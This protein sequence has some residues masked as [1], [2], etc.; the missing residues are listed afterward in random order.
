MSS[1][2]PPTPPIFDLNLLYGFARSCLPL[3]LM[4]CSVANSHISQRS[5]IARFMGPTW[6]TWTLL[7]GMCC[8][9]NPL[10]WLQMNIMTIKITGK[11]T[12]HSLI[13]KKSPNPRH[14]PFV[15]R[16]HQRPVFS[17]QR[18]NISLSVST[19]RRHG[20]MS[21]NMCCTTSLNTARLSET[22]NIKSKMYSHL[23]DNSS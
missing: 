19:A 5:L 2:S 14:R 21:L 1:C 17:P 6:A 23:I 13:S 18:A 3:P 20:E 7:S 15:T 10:Q 4:T 9:A 12:V 11:L 8:T 16:L 22:M